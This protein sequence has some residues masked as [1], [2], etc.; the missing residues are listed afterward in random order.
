MNILKK[1]INIIFLI[2]FVLIF[3]VKIISLTEIPLKVMLLFLV[4]SVGVI[5]FLL[6]RAKKEF[7]EKKNN[8]NQ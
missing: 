3:F 5:A 6:W 7:L 1:S 4:I 8:E 2:L